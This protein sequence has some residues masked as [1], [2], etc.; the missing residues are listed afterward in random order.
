VRG[1]VSTGESLGRL[2]ELIASEG[3]ELAASLVPMQAEGSAPGAEAFGVLV[4]TCERAQRD[5]HEY[6]LIVE[7]ICEGYL[8]HYWEGRLLQPED[9]DLR[10]LAGDFLYACGLSRLA[11]LDD[12]D[13]VTEL[14]DLISLCARVHAT[15][16]TP[17]GAASLAAAAWSVCTLAVGGGAWPEGEEAKARLREQADAGEAALAAAERRARELGASIELE[18]ALIAF[19]KIVSR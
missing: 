9:D 4:A 10:L 8:L 15:T 17:A 3:G 14:A 5:R 18:R 13:A 2:H 11:R 19:R 16:T 1:A 12:L 7:S 6:A